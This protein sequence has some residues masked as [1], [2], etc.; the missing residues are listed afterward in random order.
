[1]FATKSNLIPQIRDP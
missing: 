1:L